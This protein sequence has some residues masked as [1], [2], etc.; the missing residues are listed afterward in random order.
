MIALARLWAMWVLL[1][2]SGGSL[3]LAGWVLG[4]TSPYGPLRRLRSRIVSLALATD[5][6]ASNLG[7]RL[8]RRMLAA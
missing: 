6:W 2:I 5:A 7:R 8:A 1:R 4:R 3:W